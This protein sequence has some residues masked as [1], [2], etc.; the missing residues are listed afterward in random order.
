MKKILVYVAALFLTVADAFALDNV[1]FRSEG[2]MNT[3]ELVSTAY[4]KLKSPEAAAI[5]KNKDKM[6]S[7]YEFLKLAVTSTLVATIEEDE[8]ILYSTQIIRC[9]D[10]MTT[11]E[12]L[13][14]IF[15]ENT[16]Y[17]LKDV[18][19]VAYVGYVAL[20]Q[21]NYLKTNAYEKVME[22]LAK[23]GDELDDSD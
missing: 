15:D 20:H 22:R 6:P 19:I 7:S 2:S 23:E 12:L 10:K 18:P 21:C 13:Q 8:N 16:K 5:F 17:Q 1:I 3:E 9:I 11:D 4:L 14:L